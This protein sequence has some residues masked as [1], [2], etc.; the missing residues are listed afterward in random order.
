MYPSIFYADNCILF[1][2]LLAHCTSPADRCPRPETDGK[3]KKRCRGIPIVK[4]IHF[5]RLNARLFILLADS[6]RSIISI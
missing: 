2:S 4:L 5:I 6:S 1:L 3:K